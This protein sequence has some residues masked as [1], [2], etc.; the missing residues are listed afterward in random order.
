MK[1]V[2]A[3]L[4]EGDLQ[5]LENMQSAV[6]VLERLGFIIYQ[7]TCDFITRLA[8]PCGFTHCSASIGHS[9]M[10]YS[11]YNM[12]LLT[13]K[14]YVGYIFFFFFFYVQLCEA[15]TGR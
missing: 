7:E 6:N 14:S 12:M 8:V 1:L 9:L 3:S 5:G 4:T 2:I 11:L 15:R 10:S 13:N